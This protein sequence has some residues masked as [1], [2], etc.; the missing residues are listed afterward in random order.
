M[1]SFI[2]MLKSLLAFFLYN[3]YN[4]VSPN[5]VALCRRALLCSDTWYSSLLTTRGVIRCQG[6]VSRGRVRPRLSLFSYVC[7]EIA[8]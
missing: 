2:D 4:H 1:L 3:K 7:V 6:D 8:V 5:D